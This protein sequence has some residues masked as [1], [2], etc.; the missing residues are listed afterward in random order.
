M[1]KY[2][3]ATCML[4]IFELNLSAQKYDAYS[5]YQA[6]EFVAQSRLKLPYQVLY[7]ENYDKNKVYPVVFFL[8]GAGNEYSQK[9]GNNIILLFK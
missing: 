4:L 2:F 9:A 8:H 1:K 5:D 3:I 6:K 7:P